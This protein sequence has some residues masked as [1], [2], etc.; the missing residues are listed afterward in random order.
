[1]FRVDVEFEEKFTDVIS[2]DA[3]KAHAEL[4][5]MLVTLRGQRPSNYVSLTVDWPERD[6][7]QKFPQHPP[8]PWPERTREV[9]PRP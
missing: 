7:P 8:R 9:A 6:R 2:L 5:G 4:E 3:L 1:M